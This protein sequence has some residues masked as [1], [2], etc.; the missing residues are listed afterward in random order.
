MFKIPDWKPVSINDFLGYHG[1]GLARKMAKAKQLACALVKV[2]GLQ[3]GI[4][5]VR[6][7]DY[8]P[9]RR[10]TLRVE[11]AGSGRKPDPDNL[12]KIFLDGCKLAGLIVDDSANW[13][14]FPR[15][16]VVG[17]PRTVTYVTV[18]DVQRE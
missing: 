16:V 14:D 5:F 1:A 13:C 15:P 12:E 9:Y 10:V 3:A 18:E 7:P 8:L 6:E 17:G 11:I 4:R 2:Y